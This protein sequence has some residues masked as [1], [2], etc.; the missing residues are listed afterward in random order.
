MLRLKIC[1]H[2]LDEQGHIVVTV[3][4]WEYRTCKYGMCPI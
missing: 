3:R 2:L 4:Y 1:E